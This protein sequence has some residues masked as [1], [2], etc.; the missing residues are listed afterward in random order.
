MRT[1]TRSARTAGPPSV[2]APSRSR[3]PPGRPA[4][5]DE[6]RPLAPSKRHY[7]SPTMTALRRRCVT[8]EIVTHGFDAASA[9][10][11]A[12]VARHAG[13]QGHDPRPGSGQGDRLLPGQARLRAHL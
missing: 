5:T 4:R 10:G 12:H 13:W 2:T 9:K 1:A 3:P 11:D 8:H 7:H 6:F